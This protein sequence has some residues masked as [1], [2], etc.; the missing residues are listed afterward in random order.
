[1]Y[2]N[3]ACGVLEGPVQFLQG[4]WKSSFI[5][6][7]PFL[8]ILVN[9]TLCGLF[10]LT[11]SFFL[12]CFYLPVIS[13]LFTKYM[14]F[15][16]FANK[17]EISEDASA[18]QVLTQLLDGF[19]GVW[20]QPASARLI[21][22]VTVNQLWGGQIN[23][24]I[25]HLPT[26]FGICCITEVLVVVWTS[27]DVCTL[28]WE[29]QQS[30][31]FQ[32]PLTLDVSCDRESPTRSAHPLWSTHTHISRKTRHLPLKEVFCFFTPGF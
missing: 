5:L 4:N 16:F 17:D 8:N 2:L 24:P 25:K 15:P 31:I 6:V 21:Q 32:E 20:R 18:Q 27:A 12:L 29:R 10:F 9:W 13:S 30:S 22:T 1:M 28:F 7:I 19:I 3:S 11:S 26:P 14:N 23:S